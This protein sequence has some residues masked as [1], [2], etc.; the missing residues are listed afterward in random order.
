M[1]EMRR[2]VIVGGGFGGLNCARALS[3]RPDL[4]VTLVRQTYRTV[5]ITANGRTHVTAVTA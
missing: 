4:T 2:V 1:R 5:E 3:G